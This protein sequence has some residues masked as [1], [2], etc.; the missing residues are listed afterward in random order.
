MNDQIALAVRAFVD[1]VLDYLDA[2]EMRAVIGA[3]ELVVITG[4]VNHP[5]A[6]ADPAQHLLH[7]VVMGLRPVPVG[8]QRPA[9]DDVANEID[10]V[11][12]V[13]AEKV[14]ETVGLRA[15]GSEM[16]VGDKQSAKASFWTT[17]AHNL[18]FHGRAL[19]KIV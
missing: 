2:A 16:D 10:D 14:E 15:A 6:L 4:N 13:T 9:V 8:F 1:R 11:G 7:E 17:V 18:S 5:R 3:Q 12:V 19:I